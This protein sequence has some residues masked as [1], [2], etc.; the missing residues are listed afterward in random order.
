[1]IIKN[2]KIYKRISMLMMTVITSF[3]LLLAP[4]HSFAAVD[5]NQ[6]NWLKNN[7]H[8]IKSLESDDYTDLAFLKTLLKDKTVVS[9]GENFHRV[10]EY[11]EIKTRLIKYL[12]EELG[13]DV[14]AFESGMG[15][16]AAV[17]EN[18]DSLSP[19]AMMTS[20]IFPIWH[21]QE[22]LELFDY[23]KQQGKGDNPLYLAGYDMQFTSSYLTQFIAGGIAQLDLDR[24]KDFVQFELQAITDF[25]EVYN[26]YGMDSK[27]PAFK[28]EMQKVI[29]TYEPQYQEVIKFI[30]EHRAELTEKLAAIYPDQPHLCDIYL[31]SLHDH[32]EFLKSG[33]DDVTNAY[34]SRDQLMTDN[35]DWVM[36]TLY[37]GKKVILW[38]HNDHLAKNTSN[39][40]VKEDGKWI[41]SFTS[42]GELLHQK[43]QDKMYVIGLFMNQGE[44]VTISSYKPFTI[45]PATKGSLEYQVMQSG[46]TNTFIDFTKQKVKDNN[47]TWMF[48]H[49]YASEDGL[50]AEQ[51]RPNVMRFIPQQQFDGV[52]VI[53]KVKAPTPIDYS[54][55]TFGNEKE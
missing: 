7:A 10:A 46:Y 38:A 42:M 21:S 4:A 34:S 25:Y 52:I 32:I 50:T 23:I 18:R 15:D 24:G 6:T 48:R 37:P 31:K 13:F 54:K 26:K 9:L 11:S 40:R 27:E 39:I 55:I 22:T 5:Q 51:I 44:T 1:M 29:D 19:E 14:I 20:S 53:D 41:Y 33:L 49:I 30:E 28:T 8:E 36:K 3:S 45:E 43:L 47:N 12:H 17:Y 16:A 2:L 35:L